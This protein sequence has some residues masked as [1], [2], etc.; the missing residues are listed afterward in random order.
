MRDLFAPGEI[1]HLYRSAINA[2]TEQQDFEVICFAIPKNS[3]L[4]EIL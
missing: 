3:A 1:D 2:V 4:G